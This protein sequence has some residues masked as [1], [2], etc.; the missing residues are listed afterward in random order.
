[1]NRYLGINQARAKTADPTLRLP[2]VLCTPSMRMELKNLD[3]G[4]VWFSEQNMRFGDKE[5]ENAAPH[6]PNCGPQSQLNRL[7]LAD[8]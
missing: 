7:E 5:R 4:I 8:I 3:G 6:E 2:L 1:M